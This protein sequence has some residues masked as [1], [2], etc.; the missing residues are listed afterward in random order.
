MKTRIGFLRGTVLLSATVALLVPAATR[1]QTWDVEAGDYLTAE[2]YKHLSKDEAID[3]CRELARELDVQSD[4]A[5]AARAAL[6]GLASEIESL[7]S[8]LDG[9][10]S[11][12]S[13][14]DAE[15][16][17]LEQRLRTLQ[18]RPATYTVVPNDWLRKISAMTRIYSSEDKWKRIYRGNREEIRDPNLIYPG[19]VL[20]IP[21]STPTTHT[22]REGETLRIIAGYWEIYGDRNQAM[23][24][25]EAN[26]DKI[27]DPDVIHPG[28]VLTIPR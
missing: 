15:V 7:Q 23:R 18:E 11:A 10:K 3:Y 21:R 1:A 9:L 13:S 12:N 22:V 25:Y 27:K 4:N 14:L 19:Q 16:A 26:R 28:M 8:E 17:D 2:E 20:R 6:P 5:Q 24:I